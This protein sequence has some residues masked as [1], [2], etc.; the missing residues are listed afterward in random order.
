MVSSATYQLLCFLCAGFPFFM[1]SIAVK[2]NYWVLVVLTIS[3]II[4][5]AM[6]IINDVITAMADICLSC[7][8]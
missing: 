7:D 4:V 2:N 8:F 1:V 5:M 6:N 3:V